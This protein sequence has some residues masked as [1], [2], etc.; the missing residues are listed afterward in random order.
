V[1]A[2][3]LHTGAIL[4]ENTSELNADASFCSVS[5][6]PGLVFTGSV[7][8]GFMRG[9]DAAT[10]TRLVNPLRGIGLASP[11]ASVDGMLLVGAGIGTRNGNPSSQSEI[12]AD[13]DSPLTAYGL[14]DCGNGALDS[15]E[16]CD[17]RGWSSGDG[18]S[19][20]CQ[21]E[22]LFECTGVPSRCSPRAALSRDQQR[23]L[24]DT[25]TQLFKLARSHRRALVQCA[26]AFAGGQT[27][28]AESCVD[29]STEVNAAEQNVSAT[30]QERCLAT[31]DQA[32]LYG[33]KDT[34]ISL[35]AIDSQSAALRKSL[36]GSDLDGALA[37]RSDGRPLAVCQREIAK[38]SGEL[39]DA[40]WNE[41]RRALRG[42]MDGNRRLAGSGPTETASDLA[43][44]IEARIAAD[45]RGVIAARTTRISQRA[46]RA[47]GSPEVSAQLA[48]LFPGDCD[49]TSV[50][51]L[52]ACGA[53]IARC[54][55]C[56]S[57]AR[58][59]GLPLECDVLDD[60]SE[61]ESC[62]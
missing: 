22:A 12:A 31:P 30:V 1:H 34:Q 50:A 11:M 44:E 46:Q 54:R 47:C 14:P 58:S 28:S 13:T 39:S 9:Y 23:C 59:A 26:E 49:T 51:S 29:A 27:P 57:A 7:L 17:D 20:T 35:A 52:A 61:N 41:L 5:G 25:E 18:C 40:L 36:F 32:P 16:Q 38:R 45:P 2:V 15:G 10:G 62:P 8:G 33:L 19:N 53:E 37:T 56:V 6:V 55:F 43:L 21:I 48:T 24:N 4:W 3:D 42:V 60:G